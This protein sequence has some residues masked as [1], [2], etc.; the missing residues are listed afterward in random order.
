MKERDYGNG[1]YWDE[2]Y[3]KDDSLFDWYFEWDEFN[4]NILTKYN[5][6]TPILIVGCGNSELS[7]CLEKNGIS[8][9]ISIDISHT[10]IEKFSKKKLGYFLPMDVR[11]M[12]FKNNS[13]SCVI[14]KGTLDALLCSHNFES[15][16]SKMLL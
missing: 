6:K 10:I 7:F 3:K 9:I 15:D 14:D 4:K 8:P 5:L 13:F 11:Q 2:R 1:N 12:Y 16:V